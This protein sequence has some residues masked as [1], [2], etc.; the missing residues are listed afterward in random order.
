MLRARRR[1]LDSGYYAPLRDHLV[2]QGAALAATRERT[3]TG[4]GHVADRCA[5]EIGCGEGYYI[6][7]LAR[8]LATGGGLATRF[9]GMDVS[10][11]AVRL[12]AKRHENVTFIVGNVRHQIYLHTGSVGVLLS[13]FAPRNAA[14]FAR[15]TAPGG[16]LLIVIPSPA[17]LGSLRAELDL[18]GVEDAKEDRVHDQFGSRFTMVRRSELHYPLDLSPDAVAD[19]VAM[20]PNRWHT[21]P[22]SQ[23]DPPGA[24]TTEASFVIL[25]FERDATG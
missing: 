24:R 3:G 1:F 2:A 10:K 11:A 7:A 13:V 23:S 8:E 6:G 12:A 9:V 25:Q 19:L 5:A 4:P 15:V 14:E 16:H 21:S 22:G 18:I 17:H 20:G